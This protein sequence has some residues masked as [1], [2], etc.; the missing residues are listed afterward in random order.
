MNENKNALDYYLGEFLTSSHIE[1]DNQFVDKL[2]L[3]FNERSIMITPIPD[4][5]ELNIEFV[6]NTNQVNS[7]SSKTIFNEFIGKKLSFTWKAVNSNGYFDLLVF[8]FDNLQPDISILSEG[9]SLKFFKMTM[10]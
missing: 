2:V 10:I 7:D 3:I 1:S 6:N 4:T 8:A 5:D 9:S